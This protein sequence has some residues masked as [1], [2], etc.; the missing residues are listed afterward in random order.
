[1]SDTGNLEVGI[2]VICRPDGIVRGCRVKALEGN[3]V[4]VKWYPGPQERWMSKKDVVLSAKWNKGKRPN[5]S[6][7]GG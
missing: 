6:E 7:S 5:Q 4:K 3:K 1:M 2:Q